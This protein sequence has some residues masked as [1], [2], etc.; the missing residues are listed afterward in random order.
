V[1]T[2]TA[3]EIAERL[4]VLIYTSLF[5]NS[6]KP[7]HGNFV[8]ERMRFLRPYADLSV[9]APVPYFPRLNLH[10][11]WYEFARIPQVEQIAGFDLEHPRYLVLPKMAMATHGLSMFLGSLRR[12]R[13]KVESTSFDV[14]DAH[15]IYPDGFAAVLLGSLLNKPVVVSARGSDINMFPN[16]FTV[17]PLIQHVL[18]RADA[19]I[20]VSDQLKQSMIELGC[21]AGKITVIGNGVDSVKFQPRM[22]NEM[23]ALLGLPLD[24]RILLSVGKLTENKGFHVLIDAV[25]RLRQDW[26]EVLLVIIGEGPN[27]PLLERQIRELGLQDIV[28]LAGVK[29]HEELCSWYN[30]ADLFCLASASEGCPNVVME[31]LAC[32]IPVVSTSVAESIITSSS[33]GILARREPGEFRDALDEA[34]RR[35]WDRN[36]I[37]AHARANS[38]NSVAQSVL[39]VFCDVVARRNPDRFATISTGAG[40]WV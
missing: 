12:V 19:V 23:R 9:V 27:Q 17:R 3:P 7:I 8:M 35:E 30:A 33:V 21:P 29:G 13:R 28:V 15:Y 16:F 5:P 14:I 25:S 1:K 20:A 22:R 32:G 24:R 26:P 40:Q 38:W 31:A 18:N 37:V 4:R 11:R 39:S 10:E 34:L 6:V 36:A 2:N